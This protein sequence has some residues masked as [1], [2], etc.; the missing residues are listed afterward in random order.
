MTEHRYEAR[1]A[2]GAIFDLEDREILITGPEHTGSSR[3]CMEKLVAKCQENPGTLGMIIRKVE[4][5]HALSTTPI[6]ERKVM[7][8]LIKANNVKFYNAT[9]RTPQH[10]R[11]TT[12]D[13]MIA[14]AGV[15][16]SR[17]IIGSE[18][19]MIVVLGA[20]E[21]ELTDWE[22]LSMTL[23]GS[24]M[25]YTQLLAHCLPQWPTHWLN[26]R[27][28]SGLTTKLDARHEDNPELFDL[29][30]GYHVLTAQGRAILGRLKDLTGVN[31]LRNGLGLWAPAEGLIYTRFNSA[32]HVIKPYV[33]PHDWGRLWGVD[34][35]YGHPFAW[36][37]W[38]REPDGRL[39]LFQEIHMSG[40]TVEKHTYQ[41]LDNTTRIGQP[42]PEKIACDHDAEDF[43]TMA[44]ILS[45]EWGFDVRKSVMV[46]ARKSVKAGIEAVDNRLKLQ[47]IAIMHGCL[48]EVDQ[49]AQER[50]KPI[51]F[52]SE[53][54]S[55]I[56]ANE[57]KD[58]PVKK[59]DDS[60]DM[61][62]YVVMEED[63]ITSQGIR[64]KRAS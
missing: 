8:E 64:M 16:D 46:R 61:G 18:N 31:W 7:P 26:L 42:I 48:L 63:A 29:Q 34:W 6:L 40:R 3:A 33:V 62:R 53:I 38:V 1:G 47:D 58:Q 14:L 27:C 49:A 21:L 28:Q 11:F 37:N 15:D 13:S 17:K 32:I 44:E 20:T 25:G 41:I 60:L 50:G 52:V 51:D 59:D 45:Q 9:V 19:D 43:E 2:H 10:Y 36:G 56:W 35:G 12:N 30:D 5:T 4:K 57:S 55:Y 39:V 54:N 24:A 22:D 23:S